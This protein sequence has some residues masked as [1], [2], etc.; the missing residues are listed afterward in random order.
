M[1]KS[2]KNLVWLAVAS[3]GTAGLMVWK[4]RQ[5]E[6]MTMDLLADL[7][8]FLG[9]GIAALVVGLAL[10]NWTAFVRG[11]SRIV[12]ITKKE[13]FG[14]FGSWLGYFILLDYLFIVGYLFYEI[15]GYPE[16]PVN[17]FEHFGRTLLY[18]SMLTVPMITMRLFAE[19]KAS[20]TIEMLMTVP[21]S[22][23]Q[24]VAGKFL[25]AVVF[26]LATLVPTVVFVFILRE[27]A[28][29][30]PPRPESWF[31]IH[32]WIAHLFRHQ[33]QPELGLIVTSYLGVFL[34]GT[35]FL[36]I[37]TLT[38]AITKHQVVAGMVTLHVI[39][40]L[41]YMLDFLTREPWNVPDDSWQRWIE[42]A[43]RYMSF[44][45]HLDPFSKGL[46]DSR[47]VIYCVT[48]VFFFL[49]LTVKTLEIRRWK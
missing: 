36:A 8:L 13:L 17:L 40:V 9:A 4:T 34:V 1:L 14:Y 23:V 12:T 37:G 31:K 46:I 16:V 48:S 15:V 22:E 5:A 7:Y 27:Y 43:L 39:V 28:P 47:G 2:M 29:G 20:G 21:V 19:E 42:E 6:R 11:M 26:Y 24:V 18:F 30:A 44:A 32:L 45:K 33:E 38:S 10:L 49:F 25:A 3:L 35:I 41:W